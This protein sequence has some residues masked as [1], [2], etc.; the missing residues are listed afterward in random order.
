LDIIACDDFENYDQTSFD[1][2][3][4]W[5]TWSASA[6]SAELQSYSWGK[7]IKMQYGDEANP[8]VL[9]NPGELDE[10][11]YT[12]QWDMYIGRDNTAYFNVQKDETVGSEF[13]VQVFF[14]GDANGRVNINGRETAFDYGQ[15]TWNK[16]KLSLDFENNEM[17][18]A[19]NSV[20]LVSWPLNWSATTEFGSE[21]FEALNFY[22]IDEDARFWLDEF[23]IS[24]GGEV[25]SLANNFVAA[26][27]SKITEK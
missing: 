9:Y 23:C 15:N 24:Q 10:G 11:V 21:R 17:S 26:Q 22:A 18:F 16:M 13:G 6:G 2:A 7:V 3:S 12:I 8:D 19:I 4:T 27:T 1:A 25:A 5:S 20:D 14:D